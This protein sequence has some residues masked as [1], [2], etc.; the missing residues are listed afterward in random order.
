MS[1]AFF[2]KFICDLSLWFCTAGFVLSYYGAQAKPVALL[3]MAVCCAA[4]SSLHLKKP[5]IRLLPLLLLAAPLFLIRTPADAMLYL[6]PVFYCIWVCIR[7]RFSLSYYNSY[8]FFKSASLVLLT[9]SILLLLMGQASRIEHFSLPFVISF[10]FSGVLTMRLLRHDDDLHRD[11]RLQL[12]DLSSLL[13]FYFLAFL[14][15]SPVFLGILV[16]ALGLLF[17]FVL[18]PLLLG[19]AYLMLGPIWLVLKLFSFVKYQ[20]L[21]EHKRET[22]IDDSS[23]NLTSLIGDVQKEGSLELIL[24]ALGI[25][26][27]LTLAYWFFRRIA[28]DVAKHKEG[29]VHEFR[30]AAPVAPSLAFLRQIWAPRTPR[31]AVRHYYR[32]FLH[33]VVVA[34]GF[35]LRP[36]DTSE[37]ILRSLVDRYDPALLSE[38]RGLYIV[39][40]YSSGPVTREDA[41]RAKELFG[42]LKVGGGID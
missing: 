8:A 30:N 10:L 11:W 18:S 13:A 14:L 23:F 31:D 36:C 21:P 1:I 5:H 34:G 25:V 37:S 9:L 17:R 20:A 33:Q 22:M 27:F 32:R 42:R 4:A 40:R 28:G 29:G 2:A 3:A 16:K 19:V 26:A 39:A 35:E 15:S 24:A 12:I 7:N 38:L 41:R 6:P